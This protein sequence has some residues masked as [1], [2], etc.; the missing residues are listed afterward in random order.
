MLCVGCTPAPVVYSACPKVSYCPM[1]KSDPVV[2]GDLSAD[3][4]RLEHALA[5]CALQNEIV[6]NC[7]DKLDEESNQ[8]SQGVN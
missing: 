7:Q 1:P 5:A 4:R 6:K 2:N 3:I 8:P